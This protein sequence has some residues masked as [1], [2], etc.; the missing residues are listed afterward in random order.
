MTTTSSANLA[1][2]TFREIE[3]VSP[4]TARALIP[5]LGGALSHEDIDVQTFAGGQ[6]QDIVQANPAAAPE[7]IPF[8]SAAF[9]T[10]EGSNRWGTLRVLGEF[11]QTSPEAAL[12]V[13]P[14]LLKAF[15]DTDPSIPLIAADALVPVLEQMTPETAAV[16][17]PDLILALGHRIS[18]PVQMAAADA[19]K[20]IGPAASATLP[21]LAQAQE[22]ALTRE[23][24][25]LYREAIA[26]ISGG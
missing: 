25:T 21:A 6:L 5:V 11:G 1:Q 10:R 8:L 17:L 14:I 19:L 20:H 18:P 26:A 13:S 24:K 23:E 3:A 22:S 16:F 12:R 4:E 7:A 2:A 15:S 9:D